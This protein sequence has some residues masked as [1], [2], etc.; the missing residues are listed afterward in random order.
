MGHV[1]ARR[2]ATP[3]WDL[4]ACGPAG[5]A[6]FRLTLHYAHTSIIE[7]F[8]DL[9]SV[10]S[11]IELAEKGSADFLVPDRQLIAIPD[12]RELIEQCC[13]EE[14]WAHAERH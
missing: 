13:L 11:A 9:P 2:S 3:L 5:D 14:V 6:P 1:P 7:Y 8:L 12:E 4:F 10:F